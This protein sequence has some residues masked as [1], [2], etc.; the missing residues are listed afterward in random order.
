MIR[1]PQCDRLQRRHALEQ[2]IDVLQA[3]QLIVLQINV[4]EELEAVHALDACD[5]VEAEL[6]SAAVEARRGEAR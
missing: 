5:G 2:N 3:V 1:L 6:Q 4:L